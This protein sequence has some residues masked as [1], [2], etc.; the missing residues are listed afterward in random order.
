[1]SESCPLRS[2]VICRTSFST[3][4]RAVQN[5]DGLNDTFSTVKLSPIPNVG[6]RAVQDLFSAI[7]MQPPPIVMPILSATVPVL[8]VAVPSPIHAAVPSPIRAA[9]PAPSHAAMAAPFRAAVAAPILPATPAFPAATPL[10]PAAAPIQ[11]AA[12]GAIPP[13]APVLPA[14]APVAPA[15]AIPPAASGDALLRRCEDAAVL[16]LPV[17]PRNTDAVLDMTREKSRQDRLVS[18]KNIRLMRI[19]HRATVQAAHQQAMAAQEECLY[20]AAKREELAADLL[21]KGKNVGEQTVI[22]APADC[23]LLSGD[24]ARQIDLDEGDMKVII[25][26][27]MQFSYLLIS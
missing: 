19:S 22:P 6:A 27:V 3:P 15:A 1:M 21:A 7:R 25:L 2:G 8:P 5:A 4:R 9:V 17:Q 13:A 14:A 26:T 20:W 16:L 18:A 10:Q 12:Q 23:P 24:L 11:P